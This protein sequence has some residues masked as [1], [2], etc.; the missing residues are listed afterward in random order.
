MDQENWIR[1]RVV[2]RLKASYQYLESQ[3]E[4]QT[5]LHHNFGNKDEYLFKTK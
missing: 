3:E 1:Q 4:I 5:D 2:Q